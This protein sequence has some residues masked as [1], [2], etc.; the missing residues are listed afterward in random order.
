MIDITNA[1]W[2]LSKEEKS[3]IKWLDDNEYNG[4]ILKQYVSKTVFEISKD[5]ITDNFELPQGIDFK[6]IKSYMEQFQKNWNMLCEL[7]KL[8]QMKN[9]VNNK[10]LLL[11]FCCPVPINTI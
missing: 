11:S 1:K 9:Q 4:K 10:N 6:Q 7:K 3:V 8:R 5:G 2:D